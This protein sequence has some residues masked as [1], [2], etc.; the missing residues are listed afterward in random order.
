[1]FFFSSLW[2]GQ[3]IVDALLTNGSH[4]VPVQFYQWS[5]LD[6]SEM[7]SAKIGYDPLDARIQAMTD[8]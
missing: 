5:E 1:L 8:L 7:K 3:Q 6:L 2:K 4:E